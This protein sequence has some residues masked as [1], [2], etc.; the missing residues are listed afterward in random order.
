MDSFEATSQ[1]TQALKGLLLTSQSLTRAAHF[2]LKNS[3]SED[4]LFRAILD[5][6]DDPD[7]DLNCKCSIFQ[8]VGVLL[9]E[10]YYYSQLP[11]S[12]YNYPYIH[13]LKNAVPTMILKVLPGSNTTGLYSV[14]N[15]LKSILKTLKL[16]YEEY[17][18]QYAS[19]KE[20]LTEEDMQNIDKDV[21][22]GDDNFQ[23][24]ESTVDP[25][26]KAWR[27]L[28]M[29][30][31]QSLYERLRLLKH[32]QHSTEN[33][34]DEDMFGVRSSQNDDN[35]L[36]TK[37]QILMR[38]EDD[39]ES[40][41]RSKESLWLVNRPRDT[42]VITE[43]EFFTQYWTKIKPYDENEKASFLRRLDDLNSI[44]AASY[45]DKQF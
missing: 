38:M 29:K 25:I 31:K 45:K 43:D 16:V 42:N 3:D 22:F 34:N 20:L 44:V 14:F 10:S 13:S 2:A 1:F 18:L 9:H 23:V 27:L 39:R 33:H 24:D 28:V 8:L 12:N 26:I 5:V 36:L 35:T 17:E 40:H 4:Y 30:K 11:K 32:A 19:G 7:V 21:P 15:S 6:I 41:K 37:K